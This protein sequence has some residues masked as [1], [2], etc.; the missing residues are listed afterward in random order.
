[1]PIYSFSYVLLPKTPKPHKI[2]YKMDDSHHSLDYPTL[3]QPK[4]EQA[5][6][7]P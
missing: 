7:D 5:A 1:L 6:K 2:I 3:D 4:Q